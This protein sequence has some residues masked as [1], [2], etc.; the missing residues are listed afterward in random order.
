MAYGERNGWVK[1]TREN[2]L[3]IRLMEGIKS[4]IELAEQFGINK[5]TVWSI[6]KRRA[7]RWL[8]DEPNCDI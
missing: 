6:Q 5:G 8:K 1:L 2:V 4:R 7:W 3:E